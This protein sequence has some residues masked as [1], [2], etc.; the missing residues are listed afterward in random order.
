MAE[1][2]VLGAAELKQ[3]LLLDDV[4]AGVQQAYL[5]KAQGKAE[6]FPLLFHDFS[7]NAADMD[8]KSG[9]LGSE[10]VFGLKLVSFF[11][12]N[13]RCGQAPFPRW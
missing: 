10:G 8:I 13:I 4:L 3:V 11:E 6:T 9:H 2:R 7:P 12:D 1:I 5:A